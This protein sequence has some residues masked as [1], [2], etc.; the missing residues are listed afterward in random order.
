MPPSSLEKDQLPT[1]TMTSS[2]YENFVTTLYKE[3]QKVFSLICSHFLGHRAV[4]TSPLMDI[5]FCL[6]LLAKKW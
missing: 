2:T 5:S 1:P 3:C 4:L 6:Y